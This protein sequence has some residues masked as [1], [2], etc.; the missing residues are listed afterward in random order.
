MRAPSSLVLV[1]LF[2]LGIMAFLSSFMA[3]DNHIKNNQTDNKVFN[4][5][6]SLIE[7]RNLNSTY[8]FPLRTS[9]DLVKHN[10]SSQ[11]FEPMEF[12]RRSIKSLDPLAVHNGFLR[13]PAAPDPRFLP[14]KSDSTSQLS[15]KESFEPTCKMYDYVRFWNKRFKPF[16]CYESPLRHPLKEKAPWDEQKYV[17]FQPDGGGWNNIRMAAETAMMFA[18]TTGRTLVMPPMAVWYLLDKNKNGD[19]NKSNFDK[20]FDLKKIQ[21]AMTVISMETFLENVAYKGLLK[22]K[23]PVHKDNLR[24]MAR[25]GHRLWKYLERACY[26]QE[27]EPGKRFFGFNLTYVA[28]LTGSTSTTPLS[29]ADKEAHIVYGSIVADKRLKL[30]AAHNRD[31]MNYNADWNKHRAIYF[32]GDYRDQYRLLTH[33]YSYLY[34]ADPHVEHIHKRIVRDRL[35]Y[36]DDIFCSAGRVVRLLHHLAVAYTG[37]DFPSKEN[38]NPKTL[39]GN[40][41]KDAT[42]LAVHIRRGDFQYEH[43]QI[44]AERIWGNIKHLLN[45]SRTPILYISTDE[46]NKSFFEPFK[47][48]AQEGKFEI[49][50]LSDFIK[51]SKLAGIN[52]NHIGMIEQVICANAYTFIGTPLSTF[53]GYITRMRGYY[54]DGRY[55]R[56]YY[57]MRAVTYQLHTQ[58]ELEGPFWARE[59]AVAHR[60]IDDNPEP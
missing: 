50:F 7:R 30:Q 9:S 18:F 27:W 24:E 48:N 28:D 17:V 56:T 45:S 41:N 22:E 26:Y 12:L 42:Y 37:D 51:P 5:A 14:S 53:T 46:R 29:L 49:R 15:C 58:P 39:G 13:H 10:G 8:N 47:G 2:L 31:V 6:K 20:F 32:P 4:F 57:T 36:H 3:L 38:A 34:W 23:P 21:E 60:D 33:F 54:R 40:T 25:D 19:D 52:Q 1:G 59:F 11:P 35:H 44:P 16:D 55:A 43:T